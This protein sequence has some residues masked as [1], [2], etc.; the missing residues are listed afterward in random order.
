MDY[1]NSST[2]D[3]EHDTVRYASDIL[4]VSENDA[5][6]HI[7]TFL[8][9]T[10]EHARNTNDPSEPLF[11][12]YDS[13]LNSRGEEYTDNV[14]L[15]AIFLCEATEEWFR[16]VDANGRHIYFV[17]VYEIDR[18]CGGSE[19]GGWWYDSGECVHTVTCSSEDLDRVLDAL[20]EKFP[21]TRKRYSVL[22]GEDYDVIVEKEVGTFFPK[23]IPHYE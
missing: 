1:F 3:I 16:T 5:G 20:R 17:N 7:A 2:V 19:E 11:A 12:E 18:I 21:R 4:H 23:E 13:F 9:Y 14:G 10:W 6:T 15:K 8:N 22:G